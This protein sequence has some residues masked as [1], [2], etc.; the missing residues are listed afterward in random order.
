MAPP[1]YGV[2]VVDSGSGHSPQASLQPAATVT[3]A[4]RID[5]GLNGVLAQIETVL[6]PHSYKKFEWQPIVGLDA[7]GVSASLRSGET[8]Q[9]YALQI[10]EAKGE[11]SFDP[12]SGEVNGSLGLTVEA[13]GPKKIKGSAELSYAGG[14]WE[15]N[16]T[17]GATLPVIGDV[18]AELVL[19]DEE[20]SLAVEVAPTEPIT[21]SWPRS[22][23]TGKQ[24]GRQPPRRGSVGAEVS[25]ES[26]SIAFNLGNMSLKSG[27]LSGTANIHVPP[28]INKGKDIEVDFELSAD[29]DKLEVSGSLANKDGVELHKYL[30]L[31]TLKIAYSSEK[32]LSFTLGAALQNLGA[33]LR[34]AGVEIAIDQDGFRI[35][36]GEV[37]ADFGKFSLD[38]SFSY[39]EEDGF[40]FTGKITVPFRGVELSAEIDYRQEDGESLLDVTFQVGNVGTPESDEEAEASDGLELFSGKEWQID[41]LLPK[42]P[43][44]SIVVFSVGIASATVEIAVNLGCRLAIEPVVFGGELAVKGINLTKGDFEEISITGKLTGGFSGALI[45]AP[46][47]GVGASVFHPFFFGLNA[48]VELAVIAGLGIDL[49]AEGTLA[50]DSSGG[51]TGSAAFEAPVKLTLAVEPSLFAGFEALG[52]L[53]GYEWRT[54]SVFFGSLTIMKDQELFSLSFDLGNP[55]K[56]PEAKPKKQTASGALAAKPVENAAKKQKG[57]SKGGTLPKTEPLAVGDKDPRATGRAGEGK[58]KD[59]GM[60][61][62]VLLKKLR[63]ALLPKLLNDAIDTLEAIWDVVKSFIDKVVKFVDWLEGRIQEIVTEEEEVVALLRDLLAEIKDLESGKI[64]VFFDL[65]KTFYGIAKTVLKKLFAKLHEEQRVWLSVKEKRYF[66]T[67]DG[68][69][70]LY[71]IKL[72]IPGIVDLD[73]NVTNALN[74]VGIAADIFGLPI[75]SVAEVPVLY[76]ERKLKTISENATEWMMNLPEDAAGW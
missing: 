10:T 2:Q 51:I 71:N 37:S 35:K 64:W 22:N 24:A 7:V 61:F 54:P 23:A 63:E 40:G 44:V 66:I 6:G 27:S 4:D 59:E 65:I 16:G 17:L 11:L 20:E 31:E 53:L 12:T 25:L 68:A 69:A 32:G 30:K 36:K 57:K 50:F 72:D 60:D 47:V 46:A 1:A 21:F 5:A 18:S 52:G 49:I 3:V 38:V 13:P 28:S 58:T 8:I 19:S 70:D 26:G 62:G 73:M 45:F 48:G 55:E 39:N 75:H 14:A 67:D 76:L 33:S 43:K 15:V 29:S 9:V 34:E 74:W 41:R 56:D 42:M